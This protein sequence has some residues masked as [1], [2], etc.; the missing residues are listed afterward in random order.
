FGN[1]KVIPIEMAGLVQKP[2]D[3][4][5]Q[6]ANVYK[7]EI[8]KQD[9]V[10]NKYV[11]LSVINEVTSPIIQQYKLIN[12][13]PLLSGNSEP[14]L[15]G[16]K[17][18]YTYTTEPSSQL[19]QLNRPFLL[20]GANIFKPPVIQPQ[21]III[22]VDYEVISDK[23]RAC[24]IEGVMRYKA[25]WEMRNINKKAVEYKKNEKKFKLGHHGDTGIRRAVA[26]LQCVTKATDLK[27]VDNYLI[28]CFKDNNIGNEKHIFRAIKSEPY[29][30][31]TLVNLSVLHILKSFKFDWQYNGDLKYIPLI[32]ALYSRFSEDDIQAGLDKFVNCVEPVSSKYLDF[33]KKIDTKSK[34][35][36]QE[37][38]I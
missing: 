29:S 19:R 38:I 28:S 14:M 2:C 22:N 37:L 18:T 36:V 31:F 27:E 12:N 17:F 13:E 6:V 7:N 16:L 25:L 21:Q 23:L 33:V 5:Q 8:E 1:Y 35:P 20:L 10:G 24:I 3:Y 32:H 26:L 9:L 30:L 11:L 15:N 4:E 34:L